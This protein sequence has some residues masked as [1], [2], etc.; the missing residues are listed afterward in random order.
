MRGVVVQRDSDTSIKHVE[1]AKIAVFGCSIEAAAP[2]TKGIV[3]IKSADE[4]KAYNKSEER[5]M[6]EAIKGVADRCG[7]EEEEG[8][9]GYRC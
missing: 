3:V 5:M 7:W 6:E 4:L 1:K 9:G 8:G 2:E